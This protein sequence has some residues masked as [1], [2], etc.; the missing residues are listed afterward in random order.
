MRN[1]MRAVVLLALGLAL[2]LARAAAVAPPGPLGPVSLGRSVELLE[3]PSRALTLDDVRRGPIAER[4]ERSDDD[5]VNFGYSRSALWLRLDLGGAAIAE[6]GWLLEVGFP[7]LDEVDLHLPAVAADGRVFYRTLRGGDTRPW[8][9][10]EIRDR[11]HVFRL[12][13]GTATDAPLYLRV[14][15]RSVLTVPLYLWQPRAFAARGARAQLVYGLFY[16]LVAAL[17]CYNLLLLASLRDRTHLWYVLYIGMFG[18]ALF[19][20]DGFAFEYLWPENVWWANRALG[21]ILCGTL[22]FAALFARNFLAL[23]GNLP[24]V[25][26]LVIAVAL[27]GA[28]GTLIAVV[29]EPEHY[30]WVM[31]ILS[32]VATAAG[33]TILAV[34]ARQLA[35]GYRAAR[36]FLLAWAALVVFVALAALRNFALVPT[37]FL[38]LYGLHIGLALDV[39]LLSLALADRIRVNERESALAQRRALAHQRALLE[40]TQA[41][42]RELEAGIR[43]RTRELNRANERL[44]EE[45]REREA[46]MHQLREREEHLRFMAQ[47]DPLTG[48]PN[49]ISL[50]QRL[51]LA[52]ALAKRNRKKVAVMMVDL[53]DFKRLNDARGHLVGDQALAAVAA[54]LRT[55]VRASDTVARYG[56]DEFVVLAGELDRT[57]D[58]RM[59]AEKIADMVNVPLALEGGLARMACSIGISVY[60]DDALDA[61][62]LIDRADKAMYS[63]KSE[64]GRRYAFYVV[65]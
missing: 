23:R 46:L 39:V 64:R 51:E 44:R 8:I 12:P 28:L 41:N 9:E 63:V 47:H 56:G 38:T 31:R 10:R 40:T 19:T 24:R 49:R 45:A 36:F 21:A 3:D 48:L 27:A 25:D 57:E 53:D 20:L 13:A 14:S 18:L 52:L 61:E 16:G 15:T 26:Q 29:G 2:G 42:E 1:A 6:D 11:A 65:A 62:T 17:F 55:S 22:A 34:A 4:F 54:R 58:A 5:V 50:Q 7:S 59:I 37:H 60:P 35:R 30:S 33:V 32:V 43:E